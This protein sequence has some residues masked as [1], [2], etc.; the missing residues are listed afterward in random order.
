MFG[1]TEFVLATYCVQIIGCTLI[2]LV[3][4]HFWRVYGR[5]AL[6]DWS[7][8][9]GCLSLYHIIAVTTLFTV[10][11][12]QPSHPVR[13]LSSCF[14]LTFGYWQLA[15]LL[16]GTLS[17]ARG[18]SNSSPYFRL[19]LLSI[20]IISVALTLSTISSSLQVRL[21]L[22]V[23]LRAILAHLV[24]WI[25]AY[26]VWN[27][28]SLSTNFGHRLL[29]V[30]L[31]LYGLEQSFY[32]VSLVFPLQAWRQFY[33]YSGLVDFLFQSIIGLGM[34]IW[35]LEERHEQ[36]VITAENLEDNRRAL[37]EKKSFIESLTFNSPFILYVFNV[38]LRKN[39][40]VN[41]QIGEDLGYD[42]QQIQEMGEQFLPALLHPEDLARLPAL[43]TRWETASDSDVLEVEYRMKH[44]DGHWC[45]FLGRD[46]VFKR[47]SEG[48][49][50]EILGFAHDISKLK[51][52]EEKRRRIEQQLQHTQKLESLG[53]LA[54]GIAH[55]F[56]NLLTSILGFTD[57]A[58]KELNPNSSAAKLLENSRAGA[59]QAADLT[60]QLLAYSGKGQFSV[61]PIDLS[62][63]T[64]Q[65]SR[66]L[67][68]SISKKCQLKYELGSSLPLIRADIIQMRQI[69]MNLV[70]NA[71]DAIGDAE[72]IILLRTGTRYCKAK[73]LQMPGAG[74]SLPEGNY[75]FL[76]VTD[77]GCGMSPQ[78]QAKIFDPFYT[79]KFT[80]RG[81]GLSAVLGIVH[82]HEGAIQCESELGKGTTFRVLFLATELL[83]KEKRIPEILSESWQGEGTV[84]LIDD[85]PSVRKLGTLILKKLGFR[86]L[87]A[88]NGA[89]GIETLRRHQESI[90]LVV[91][92][93]TM[94]RLDG[95]QTFEEIQKLRLN[96]PVVLSSGYNE[97]NLMERFSDQVPAGFL[98]KPYLVQDM[99][100]IIQEVLGLKSDV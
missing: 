30:G 12:Y 38:E 35:L 16:R 7:W 97:E 46:T 85:E 62:Q 11:I 20:L 72:G 66:L 18:D 9:W 68:V 75:V 53:V 21:A 32:W 29:A 76:E 78:T 98:R 41:R 86:V 74:E 10:G 99:E 5:K 36:A 2:A 31:F 54:G 88:A 79:T 22:R 91:L 84:L 93:L 96:I 64:K 100:A 92:D 48:K 24:L 89:D 69:I 59:E 60:N 37:E 65:I 33:Q 6:L 56:N 43:L 49:V 42:P 73:E 4:F 82:G 23:G 27:A 57:L 90:C 19:I 87:T 80:G 34:T 39:V 63:L 52:S 45:W 61:E 55:D 67:Q 94:P 13:L 77:S 95:V 1:S 50:L 3:M 81:L 58:V 47:D 44:A 71:S 15:W 25:A 26:Y 40:Y 28:L 83:H 51:H 8:S 14:A 70:I 17:F